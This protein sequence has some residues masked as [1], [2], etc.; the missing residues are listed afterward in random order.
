MTN[1]RAEFYPHRRKLDGSFDSI[2]LNCLATIFTSRSETE[3]E[4]H[5]KEHVCYKF[6][7][8]DRLMTGGR[9]PF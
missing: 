5:E 2:C 7:S 1:V 8:E 9:L 4:E 3:L 6:V